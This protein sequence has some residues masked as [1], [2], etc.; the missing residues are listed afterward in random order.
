MQ[1]IGISSYKRLVDST[2]TLEL[3]FQTGCLDVKMDAKYGQLN[4][5]LDE[6]IHI[7]ISNLEKDCVV[8][9]TTT[10]LVRDDETLS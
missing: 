9:T 5:Q 6:K 8:Y 7:G 10:V 3:H 2:D 1:S 4:K